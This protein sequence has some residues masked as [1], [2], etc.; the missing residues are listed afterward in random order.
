MIRARILDKDQPMVEML[1]TSGNPL[2][3]LG[4]HQW[5]GKVSPG[6]GHRSRN[7]KDT[8]EQT[9]WEGSPE[10]NSKGSSNTD[11]GPHLGHWRRSKVARRDSN[12]AEEYSFQF[13]FSFCSRQG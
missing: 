5:S 6:R 11:K 4:T 1:E 7:W 10:R 12:R 13:L 2:G 8:E 9:T 3:T